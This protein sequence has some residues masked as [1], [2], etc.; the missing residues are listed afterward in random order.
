MRVGLSVYDFIFTYLLTCIL[1]DL[2]DDVYIIYGIYTAFVYIKL[3]LKEQKSTL[4]L[5]CLFFLGPCPWHM[6][7]PRLGVESEL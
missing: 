3:I 6:E 2:I 5:F 4:F 7:I 1:N